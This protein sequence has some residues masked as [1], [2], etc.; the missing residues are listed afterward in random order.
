MIR[1]YQG[2]Q[3]M[4]TQVTIDRSTPRMPPSVT[5]PQICPI[6]SK[7]IAI[8]HMW[9]KVDGVVAHDYCVRIKYGK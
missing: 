1:S 5:G 6:C 3:N 8:D 2:D 7:E 9:C 4:Q